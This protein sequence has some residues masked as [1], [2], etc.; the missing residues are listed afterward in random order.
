MNKNNKESK[1]RSRS[2]RRKPQPLADDTRAR[3]LRAAAEVF[4]ELG[5]HSATIRRICSRAGVNIALVNYYF[6]DKLELYSEVLRQLAR[7]APAIRSTLE[8]DAPAEAILREVIKIRLRSACLGERPGWDV[9]ILCHE[10]ARPSPAMTTLINEVSRPIYDRFRQL[11][12]NILHQPADAEETIL[13]THSVAGQ[14]FF[15]VLASP[16]LARLSPELKMTPKKVNRIADHIADFS[17]ASLRR[18]GPVSPAG[19][20]RRRRR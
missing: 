6:G 13:S 16:I 7:H 4:A 8:Q 14:I 15:Y 1:V 10:I 11:I 17:L 18:H 19:Q 2:T 20:Q 5:Y 12:G 9:R 3:L